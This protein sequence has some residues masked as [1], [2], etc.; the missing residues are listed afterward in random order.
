[1]TPFPR[2]SNPTEPVDPFVVPCFSD[3]PA[4]A[5]QFTISLS[6]LII[7]PQAGL[8]VVAVVLAAARHWVIA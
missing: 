2:P 3:R 7:I 5:D 4:P 6:K 1:M 8:V